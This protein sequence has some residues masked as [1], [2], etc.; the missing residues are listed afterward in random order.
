LMSDRCLLTHGPYQLLEFMVIEIPE[1]TLRYG[2]IISPKLNSYLEFQNE[3]HDVKINSIVK[4][5][6]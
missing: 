5:C 6:H 4:N 3:P 2:Y 1:S